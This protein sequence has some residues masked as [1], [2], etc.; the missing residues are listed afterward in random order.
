MVAT[1]SLHLMVTF[2]SWSWLRMLPLSKSGIS[3]D[4]WGVE[5]ARLT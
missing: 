1:P 3:L 5:G 2:R 4:W